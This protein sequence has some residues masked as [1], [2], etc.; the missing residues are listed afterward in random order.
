MT[1][2][3]SEKT[4]DDEICRDLAAA[5]LL[6]DPADAVRQHRAQALFRDDVAGWSDCWRRR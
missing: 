3:H 4:A 1:P 5:G 6:H 2:I